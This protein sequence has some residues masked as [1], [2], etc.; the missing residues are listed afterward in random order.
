[1]QFSRFFS[2]TRKVISQRREEVLRRQRP[3]SRSRNT[4]RVGINVGVVFVQTQPV[5]KV[6]R[7]EDGGRCFIS[8]SSRNE[9]RWRIPRNEIT[10]KTKDEDEDEVVKIFREDVE[11][12]EWYRVEHHLLT[13]PYW[14]RNDDSET[15]ERQWEKTFAK[16]CFQGEGWRNNGRR[17]I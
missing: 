17:R 14:F 9:S 5:S 3:F 6:R 4:S 10:I 2:I 12:G 7:Q 11:E 16:G 15:K 1:M 8:T 13:R